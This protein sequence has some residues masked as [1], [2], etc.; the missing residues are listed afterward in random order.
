MSDLFSSI[1]YPRLRENIV[2]KGQKLFRGT[3]ERLEKV[4][5]DPECKPLLKFLK[6][7]KITES[8]LF[9]SILKI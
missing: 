4:L 5:N 7:D 3:Y 2:K 1:L 6:G 9:K 8:R